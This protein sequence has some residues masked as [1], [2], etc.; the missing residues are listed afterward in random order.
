MQKLVGLVGIRLAEELL[1]QLLDLRVVVGLTDGL[2]LV[3][4][5]EGLGSLPAVGIEDVVFLVRQEHAPHIGLS[6][7]VDA[8][9]RA[10]HDLDEV[11]LALSFA[12]VVQQHAGRLHAGRAGHVD[13]P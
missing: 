3:F 13:V 12:D 9:A 10:S 4:G 5:V 2:P 7:A 8:A 6:A 1:V 11:I